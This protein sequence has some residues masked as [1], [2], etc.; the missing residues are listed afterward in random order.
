MFRIAITNHPGLQE[1]LCSTPIDNVLLPELERATEFTLQ[2]LFRKRDLMT[3]REEQED[4][5]CR[6][7]FEQLQLK[8]I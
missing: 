6:A 5:V 4:S 1:E 3:F 7:A 8:S 2:F